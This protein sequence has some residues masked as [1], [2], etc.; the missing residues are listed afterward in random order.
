[1]DTVRDLLTLEGLGDGGVIALRGYHRPGDDGSGMFRYEK[2]SAEPVNGGTVLQPEKLPGR[3]KRLVD[4]ES[5]VYAEWFGAHGDGGGPIP[6]DD[7]EAIN[8]CLAAFG[9][10]RLLA[11]TYGVRGRPTHYN[12]NATY[13]AIDLGPKYRIEGT[14]RSK[15]KIKLLDGTN[16]KGDSPGN[17]YFSVLANRNFHESADHVVV[18]DLTIDCNF[19]GQDK[20]TTNHG[21]HIR[22]GNAL[23]ERVNFR[24]YGTGRHP[25]TGGSRECF[26]VHQ[27]LVY[28]DRNGSRRAAT[29]R[30]LDFTSPGHNG[31]IEGDVA[32]ITHIAL[33]GANNFGDRTWIM[34]K[35]KDPDF[36]PTNN[37]ENENNWWPSYGG[38]VENCVIHDVVHDPATQKSP[39]HG[40]T[41][42]DSIGITV[43]NNKA[44]NFDGAAV[45]VMS[46][47]NR[48]TLICD[49]DFD[50]VMIGVALHMRNRV[51]LGTPKH[52]R[53]GTTGVHL[54]GQDIGSGVRMKNLLVRDNH[55]AGRSYMSAKG[56]R[57]CPVGISLQILR[58]N[59]ERLVFKDNWLDIPDFGD[60]PYVPQEPYSMSMRYYPLAR[61]DEDARTQNVVFENNRTPKGQLLF[62]ILADWYF[63]NPPTWGRAG[64]R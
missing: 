46:W 17:N 21:I 52:V 18:R 37:G 23:V 44:V 36:D 1:V 7:K 8:A 43:R 20:H 62:P 30:D 47:W 55:I 51:R 24:G 42:G 60:S 50:G 35:G 61:W 28:K 19:D 40:I 58:A 39:L 29:Y 10:V 34:P 48:D 27:T 26:V 56:Q 6:H 64:P 53:W 4:L 41:Y 11:K 59:Y 31:M 57:M 54:Y 12:P 63:K 32:E 45:F 15:T 25:E 5:D 13:H 22:G 16:P 2:S 33:G 14:D 38:L 9:R 49:N 3:F